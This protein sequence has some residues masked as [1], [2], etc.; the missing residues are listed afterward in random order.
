MIDINTRMVE[1]FEVIPNCIWS[2]GGKLDLT[3]VEGIADLLAAET[4]TQHR[5]AGSSCFKSLPRSIAPFS[6]GV[7]S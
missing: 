4:S 1:G 2:Q 3:E 7:Q 5:Q 6:S